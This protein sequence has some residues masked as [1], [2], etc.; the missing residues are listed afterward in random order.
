MTGVI[1]GKEMI[2][3]LPEKF[4]YTKPKHNSKAYVHNG[5][6]YIEGYVDF[7]TLMYQ[8]TYALYGERCIYCG[9]EL[10]KTYRSIDHR[11]PR[12]YGGP[13]IPENLAPCCPKC[14]KDKGELTE[15]QY[16]KILKNTSSNFSQSIFRAKC[17]TINMNQCLSE[18]FLPDG[19]IQ[20]YPIKE[21]VRQ[22]DFSHLNSKSM[23]KLEVEIEE[24]HHY[25]RPI[26]LSRD[27][28]VL[29]GIHILNHARIHK[30]KVVDAI[31]L[32]NVVKVR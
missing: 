11:N 13:S 19:W 12:I 28:W 14:N 9:R 15:K 30:I 25:I 7:E 22:I 6:L 26:I 27:G 17:R 8:L 31:V 4:S 18:S 20:K 32:E 3:K 16:K 2:I 29:Y 21:L 23:K 5:F 10:D 24:F 1:R